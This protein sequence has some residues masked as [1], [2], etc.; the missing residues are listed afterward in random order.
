MKR[1]LQNGIARDVGIF[2]GIGVIAMTV[3]NMQKP[4][5]YENLDSHPR[6]KMSPFANILNMLHTLNEP[7]LFEDILTKCTKFI[8]YADLRNDGSS[9]FY[10]NRLATEIPQLVENMVKKA[11]YSPDINV[12]TRAIDFERDELLQIP[13]ICDDMVRNMLLDARPY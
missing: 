10:A 11:R 7:Q 13:S 5:V 2:A 6:L 9:G 3:K 8:E 1:L 12:A 4:S